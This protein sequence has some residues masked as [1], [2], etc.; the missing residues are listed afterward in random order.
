MPGGYAGKFLDVDLTKEKIKEV[1]FDDKVLGQYFGGR[2]LAAKILW[3]RVGKKWKRRVHCGLLAP[4][5]DRRGPRQPRR[6]SGPGP[7][8]LLESVR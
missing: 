3:D 7:D 4:C 6:T 1:S 8:G 2:G 5:R